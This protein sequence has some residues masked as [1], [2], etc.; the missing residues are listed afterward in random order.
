MANPDI[1][2]ECAAING[3]ETRS[4]LEHDDVASRCNTDDDGSRSVSLEEVDDVLINNLIE[5]QE[6][7][8]DEVIKRSINIKGHICIS[9]D[10][11]CEG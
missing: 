7:I 5:D 3:E 10:I 4:V 8:L 9:V 2:V 1:D 11:A 6:I